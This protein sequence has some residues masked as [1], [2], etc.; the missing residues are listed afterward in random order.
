MSRVAEARRQLKTPRKCIRCIQKLFPRV[1]DKT[2]SEMF[3]K[4]LEDESKFSKETY[5]KEGRKYV[6]CQES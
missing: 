6:L 3:Q 5:R 4:G 2:A 1:D